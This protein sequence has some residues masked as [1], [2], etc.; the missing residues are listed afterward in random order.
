M[1]KSSHFP[2]ADLSADPGQLIR[3][4]EKIIEEH[5]NKGAGSTLKANHIAD[6]NYKLKLA[7]DK[8]EEG[9]KYKR[10]MEDAWQERDQFLGSGNNPAG[11][12]TQIITLMMKV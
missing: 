12:V 5:I 3:L 4:A 10:L 8:H 9:L 6:L 1:D 7:K 11:G 2:P